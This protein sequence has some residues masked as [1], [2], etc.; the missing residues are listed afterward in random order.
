[1]LAVLVLTNVPYLLSPKAIFMS[2]IPKLAPIAVLV[3][4]FVLPKQSVRLKAIYLREL[5]R[6]CPGFAGLLTTKTIFSSVLKGVFPQ[7]RGFFLPY[8]ATRMLGSFY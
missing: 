5:P 6:L 1:M 8:A 4:K 2:S 7:N 3:P